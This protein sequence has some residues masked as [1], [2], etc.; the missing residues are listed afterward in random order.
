MDLMSRFLAQRRDRLLVRLGCWLVCFSLIVGL[1]LPQQKAKALVGELTLAA[2]ASVAAAYL[3]ACG[4]PLVTQGMDKDALVNSIQRLIQ[5]FLDTEL[6][7]VSI[8]DWLG[9]VWDLTVMTGKLVMGR[10]LTDEF[11]SFAQWVAGKYGTKP[12]VNAVYSARSIT[13]ADGSSFMLSHY[14]DQDAFLNGVGTYV[15]SDFF[16]G[17][18]IPVP[19]V[20]SK[21][22]ETTYFELNFY[23][24]YSLKLNRYLSDDIFC[25]RYQKEFAGTLSRWS[26]GQNYSDRD[27]FT[28][29]L[30]RDGSLTIAYLED[31]GLEYYPFEKLLPSDIVRTLISDVDLSLDAAEAYQQ[32]LDR[33][34]ALEEGQT[35]ALDVGATQSMEIQ[36]ILQDILDATLAGN[37]AAT[38][39]IVDEAAEPVDPPAGEI[40]D[41]DSLGLPALG[42]ALTSR[43]PFSIPWDIFR[44]VK[45]L[46][47]PAKAPYFEVDFMEPLADEV[48]GWK[49]STTVVLDFSQYAII[50]QVCRWTSTIGFCLMLAGATKRLIWTA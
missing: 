40:P 29:I 3:G 45:L 35:V 26:I 30:S 15:S 42:A 46:A 47:A 41:V 39:E 24:G 32:V 10:P 25:F 20:A 16:L 48:G 49:G 23:P 7:G 13:F 6:G 50:G 1:M 14:S 11:F 2:V 37:L 38:A 31:E 17:T 12:G 43:F 9:N 4:L 18:S 36:E 34:T 27:P 22:D 21:T 28:F 8:Q 33:L 5:E 19:I 44:A